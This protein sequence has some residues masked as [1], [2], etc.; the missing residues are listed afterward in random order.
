MQSRTR[1]PPCADAH[2][3]SGRLAPHTSSHPAQ[4]LRD[5]PT[6]LGR[7]RDWCRG[8]NVALLMAGRNCTGN[9]KSFLSRAYSW[10]LQL[11]AV[12]Q[13]SRVH[14]TARVLVATLENLDKSQ[15]TD[16]SGRKPQG[17]GDGAPL[18]RRHRR[19]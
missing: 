4:P 11:T 18:G 5:D 15:T 8:V 13:R 3:A 12:T 7:L 17:G 6:P 2:N 10:W 19:A 9:E 14:E 1:A 16:V